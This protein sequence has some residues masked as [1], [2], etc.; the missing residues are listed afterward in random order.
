MQGLKDAA[1]VLVLILLA[2]TIRVTPL[3]DVADL[4]PDAQAAALLPAVAAEDSPVLR[5]SSCTG[6]ETL[7]P[8]WRIRTRTPPPMGTAQPDGVG[9]DRD[10][11]VRVW[12]REKRDRSPALLVEPSPDEVDPPRQAVASDTAC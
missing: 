6:E 2:V 12:I 3:D 11:R 8:A 4:V 9:E 10:I 7:E 5:P 1:I